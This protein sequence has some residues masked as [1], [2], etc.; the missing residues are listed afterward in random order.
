MKN[1]PI[2]NKELARCQPPKPFFSDEILYSLKGFDGAKALY[3]CGNGTQQ[4]HFDS[5]KLEIEYFEA[6]IKNFEEAIGKERAKYA[7]LLKGFLK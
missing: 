7:M 5:N 2:N 6:V 4:N 1:Y 3:F